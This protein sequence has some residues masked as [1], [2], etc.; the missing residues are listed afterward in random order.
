MSNLVNV[1]VTMTSVNDNGDVENN[2]LIVISVIGEG[3]TSTVYNVIYNHSNY[4]LKVQEEPLKIIEETNN[5]SCFPHV[6]KT[7]KVGESYATLM[8]IYMNSVPLNKVMYRSD[9]ILSTGTVIRIGLNLLNN[10][11]Q[12]HINGLEYP[13]LR[14]ANIACIKNTDFNTY[15]F[16]LFDVDAVRTPSKRYED[17]VGKQHESFYSSMESKHIYVDD[18]CSLIFNMLTMLGGTCWNFKILDYHAMNDDNPFFIRLKQFLSTRGKYNPSQYDTSPY[19]IEYRRLI[20]VIKRNV[21]NMLINDI[22]ECC[23]I[24][25]CDNIH[26]IM[27]ELIHNNFNDIY[28]MLCQYYNIN[29]KQKP[30]YC[31]ILGLYLIAVYLTEL[32]YVKNQGDYTINLNEYNFIESKLKFINNRYIKSIY[33]TKLYYEP[34]SN[35]QI[36]DQSRIYV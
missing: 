25:D 31:V 29:T 19:M 1:E 36:F 3:K 15:T 8:E 21:Y 23:N 13:D 16:K 4:A 5:C 27:E 18:I 30:K 32:S 11:K 34:K 9:K 7:G 6:Y 24:I 10:L 28:H 17:K 33:H 14:P 2:N 20:D 22:K 26:E 35:T 12:I